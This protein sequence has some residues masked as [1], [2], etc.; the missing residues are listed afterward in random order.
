MEPQ[1]VAGIRRE[2]ELAGVPISGPALEA[3]AGQVAR[4]REAQRR[5]ATEGLIIT[6]PKG[7]PIP[8][9]AIQIERTAQ[10]ELRKW[11]QRFEPKGSRPAPEIGE[12]TPAVDARIPEGRIPGPLELAV[13]AAADQSPWLTV[14]DRPGL[15]ALAELAQL[16]DSGAGEPDVRGAL[17][18]R[19]LR[20]AD[21][22]GFS[23][24]GRGR[25]KTEEPTNDDDAQFL[26]LIA[27]TGESAR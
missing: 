16:I 8:H 4:L 5:L 20:G 27:G 11:G 21:A 24:F 18:S 23:P 15:E 2:L 25:I 10:D 9:P 13:Y 3:Y 7:F 6:D 17:I 12:P 1:D 26:A 14:Q 22:Y 19:L